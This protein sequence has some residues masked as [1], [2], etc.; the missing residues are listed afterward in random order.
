MPWAPPL[1]G[2][3][4][5][6]PS[7]RAP[8]QPSPTVGEGRPIRAQDCFPW[9][10]GGEGA[11]MLGTCW[12]PV[13]VAGCWGAGRSTAADAIARS[14]CLPAGSPAPRFWFSGVA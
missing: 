2:L 13:S 9:L 6:S 8:V 1:R 14:P 10:L 7:L 4:G 11:P 5:R 3:R 12:M